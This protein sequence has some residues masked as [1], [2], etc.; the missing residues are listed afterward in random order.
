MRIAMWWDVI[1][2]KC[3]SLRLCYHARRWVG[4]YDGTVCYAM[5]CTRHVHECAF[6]ACLQQTAWTTGMGINSIS[7][8]PSAWSLS[9]AN[10]ELMQEHGLHTAAIRITDCVSDYD[11][12][13]EREREWASD[14]CQ[15]ITFRHLKTNFRYRISSYRTHEASDP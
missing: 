13:R 11:E 4:L 8:Y 2:A 9:T 12:E 3:N 14:A 1:I 15:L 6:I 10:W 5:Y 7:S